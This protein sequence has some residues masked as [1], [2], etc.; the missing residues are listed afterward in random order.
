MPCDEQTLTALANRY[1]ESVEVERDGLRHTETGAFHRPH[2][3]RD[4]IGWIAASYFDDP[5]DPAPEKVR[6]LARHWQRRD[7]FGVL[8]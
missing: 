7:S 6:C 2:S 8:I 5:E 1:P 4:A 3:A